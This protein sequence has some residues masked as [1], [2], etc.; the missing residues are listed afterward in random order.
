[1]HVKGG[2]CTCIYIESRGYQVPEILVPTVQ[3][4]KLLIPYR[5]KDKKHLIR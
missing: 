5:N 2:G 4:H 3:Y 1:M